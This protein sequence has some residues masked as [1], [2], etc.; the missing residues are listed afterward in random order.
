MANQA[1]RR[2]HVDTSNLL[3]KLSWIIIGWPDARQTI[4]LTTYSDLVDW[5]KLSI[6]RGRVGNEII[7]SGLEN[8][9]FIQEHNRITCMVL[10]HWFGV[11]HT[12]QKANLGFWTTSGFT[13]NSWAGA[14]CMSLVC[15][16]VFIPLGCHIWALLL[17]SGLKLYGP[18]ACF[19]LSNPCC[20]TMVLNWFS[21]TLIGQ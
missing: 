16:A 19:I 1:N 17:K 11:T 15:I 3:S 5:G 6:L 9:S 7:L 20:G 18:Q 21:Q 10:M 13:A 4:W 12:K 2:I 14:W 8:I